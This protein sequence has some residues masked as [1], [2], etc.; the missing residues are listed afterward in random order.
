[1]V[2]RRACL[3]LLLFA[4]ASAQS[5]PRCELPGKV[6][7]WVFDACM[8]EAETDD[9]A[10]SAVQACIARTDRELRRYQACTQ[11]RILKER[12]CR[13]WVG[14]Q[15]EAVRRCVQDPGK[16]GMTVQNGGL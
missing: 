4:A 8:W 5:E 12:I 13:A 1:M 2:I 14:P 6:E 15:K 16:T 9:F 3:S 11:R 10:A 7:H